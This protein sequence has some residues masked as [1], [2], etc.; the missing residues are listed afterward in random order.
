M[1]RY[2]YNRD[3]VDNGLTFLNDANT[4]I[5][6]SYDLF[7]S[8]IKIISSARGS[9]NLN[10]SSFNFS[11]IQESISDN[12]SSLI[13]TVTN[14]ANMIDEYNAAPWWKKFTASVD[15]ANIKFTEGFLTGGEQIVDGF[16]TAVGFVAGLFSSTAKDAI[17]DFIRKD[18]VGDYFENE[19]KNGRFKD[20]EKY[21]SFSS[22]SGVANIFKGFGTA[23]FYIA[24]AAALGGSTAMNVAVAGIGGVGR[25][26][27][28][29]LQNGLSFNEAA[30]KG[31]KAGA[32]QA[33]TTY[34]AITAANGLAKAFT[35]KNASKAIS[36]NLDDAVNSSTKALKPGTNPD[37]KL[38]NSGPERLLLNS[39][40]DVANSVVNV[41]DDVASNMLGSAGDIADDV[42][43]AASKSNNFSAADA[44]KWLDDLYAGKYK[45]MKDFQS[46][47]V[48]TSG[49]PKDSSYGHDL[50]A[51]ASNLFKGKSTFVPDW[52][53]SANAG[54]SAARTAG[55]S[56]GNTV[57]NSAGST[58]G[59]LSGRLVGNTPLAL[60]PGTATSVVSKVINP[61]SYPS[62]AANTVVESI[63]NNKNVIDG[64]EIK[65][66]LDEINSEVGYK[67]DFKNFDG[68][69]SDIEAIVTPIPNPS[70]SPIDTP[71]EIPSGGPSEGPVIRP[72]GGPSED[73]IV[74]P[75]KEPSGGP[76]EGLVVRP[77]GGPSGDPIV[78]SSGDPVVRPIE[79][80]SVSPIENPR[81]SSNGGIVYGGKETYVEKSTPSSNGSTIN[82]SIINSPNSNLNS[83]NNAIIDSYNTTNNTTNNYYNNQDSCTT[84]DSSSS[85]TLK[86]VLGI[87]AAGIAGV[88][89][90]A[91]YSAVKDKKDKKEKNKYY[92]I[93]Y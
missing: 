48:N 12:I 78:G 32:I 81:E 89:A 13:T 83:Y 5:T 26:T 90:A 7:S 27:E 29:A 31:L 59:N 66:I 39:G 92:D 91:G 68:L 77:S 6:S 40:D 28:N 60:P 4:L 80:P 33:G 47:L 36:S 34:A 64:V 2:V 71:I 65:P 1:A 82:D 20:V 74:G 85:D 49:V 43:G 15:M 17:G 58:V 42:A 69:A 88:A 11:G 23:T 67:S 93:N 16:A 24:G 8:G 35:S 10:Y 61:L 21:S 9:D 45:N 3:A 53:V 25:E 41:S 79:N 38:L 37:T 14:N 72:S 18:H 44:S 75:S 62:L 55:N 70:E 54:S 87:G 86:T 73:P 76:S 51:N 56:I 30:W 22:H 84:S 46:S 19:F 52:Y 63:A 57:V 50:L